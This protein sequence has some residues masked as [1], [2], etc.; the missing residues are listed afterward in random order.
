M[1]ANE[2]DFR[3]CKV[4]RNKSVEMEAHEST[5]K[6]PQGDSGTWEIKKMSSQPVAGEFEFE[7]IFYFTCVAS[8][9]FA[10]VN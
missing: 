2:S 7:F 8:W 10:S 9:S 6:L 1:T 5:V 4:I 3:R